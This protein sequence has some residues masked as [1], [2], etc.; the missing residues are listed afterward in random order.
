M[1]FLRREWVQRALGV[2]LGLVFVYAS[3]DKIWR[4]EMPPPTAGAAPV[5]TGPAA[6]ARVVYRYQVVGPNATLPP[7]VANL[8]AV[9]LPWVELL[10]GLLLI[11][12]AWRR[13]AALVVAVLLAVFVAVVGSALARGIDLDNCGCFSLGGEGRRAGAL[14]IAGDLGLMAVAALVAFVR[15]QPVPGEPGGTG[16]PTR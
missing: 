2:A 16:R 13:E 11:F 10:A 3:H 14:L 6:F 1:S 8:V 12:G 7:T 9:T 15:P 4:R 5:I